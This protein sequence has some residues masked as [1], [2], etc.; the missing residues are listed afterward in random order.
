MKKIKVYVYCCF[1]L[2][3]LLSSA[4]CLYVESV[5]NFAAADL[6]LLAFLALDFTEV[7]QCVPVKSDIHDRLFLSGTYITVLL[8][9]LIGN[10]GYLFYYDYVA[11]GVLMIELAVL[12]LFAFFELIKIPTKRS[13]KSGQ[14]H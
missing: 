1:V 6:L 3:T 8:F 7:M 9:S 2:V 13:L 12:L 10:I 14:Y 5:Y 11:C 4:I